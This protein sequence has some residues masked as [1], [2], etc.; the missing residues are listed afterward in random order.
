METHGKAFDLINLNA[1]LEIVRS[2]L[3]FQINDSGAKIVY[4]TLP[5]VKADREQIVILLK[6]LIENSIKFRGE[7]TPQIHISS[8]FVEKDHMWQ[9]SI[10]DNGIGI[11]Q[12]Y[13][14]RIFK[15]FQRLHSIDEYDGSGIG[16]AHSKRIVERHGGTIWVESQPGQGSKFNFTLPSV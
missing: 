7:Q 11:E 12:Q 8:Q 6:N 16:L 13:F 1:A 14:E 10:Q 5:S 15:I 3:E 9:V 2:R 4:D